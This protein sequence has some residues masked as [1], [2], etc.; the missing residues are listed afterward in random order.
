MQR[1][2]DENLLLSAH[3][4]GAVCVTKLEG[5]LSN[6]IVDKS[7]SWTLGCHAGG[8]DPAAVKAL[9]LDRDRILTAGRDGRLCL[10]SLQSLLPT[11]QYDASESRDFHIASE[12]TAYAFEYEDDSVLVRRFDSPPIN[13]GNSALLPQPIRFPADQKCVDLLQALKVATPLAVHHPSQLLAMP[14][15]TG[16]DIYNVV[17]GE[18]QAFISLDDDI[19]YKFDWASDGRTLV[20]LASN[21]VYAWKTEDDGSSFVLSSKFPVD[22]PLTERLQGTIKSIAQG[23]QVAITYDRDFSLIDLT[24]QKVIRKYSRNEL[25]SVVMNES[26]KYWAV[27]S[28]IGVEAY[29]HGSSAPVLQTSRIGA[30]HLQLCDND[31]ILIGY[32]GNGLQAWHLPTG[33][34]IGE[35]P[36]LEKE[37]AGHLTDIHLTKQSILVTTTRPFENQTRGKVVYF[38]YPPPQN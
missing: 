15:A 7:Q 34:Y 19:P 35:V 14:A 21:H 28:Q 9:A 2:P 29:E 23:K 24:T 37:K 16:I 22:T 25:N 36:Y 11:R 3:L 32:G 5:E 27:G 26:E 33:T 4:N 13:A 38:G 12:G 1:I 6:A 8:V 31:R 17:T 30:I 10:W 18:K 20:G